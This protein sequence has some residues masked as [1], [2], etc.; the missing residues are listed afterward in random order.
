MPECCALHALLHAFRNCAAPPSHRWSALSTPLGTAVDVPLPG[1]GQGVA[2]RAWVSEASSSSK[3]LIV[4]LPS[5]GRPASD[6]NVLV[7][8]LSACGYRTAA[9]EYPGYS[10][11]YSIGAASAA[12]KYTLERLADELATVSRALRRQS[13]PVILLGWAFGNRPV[14]MCASRHPGLARGAV[15][16]S[17]GHEPTFTPDVKLA[18]MAVFQGIPVVGRPM[19]TAALRY[20][21]LYSPEDSPPAPVPS[22]LEQANELT[23]AIQ[24]LLG[25]AKWPSEPSQLEWVGGGGV[26]MLCVGGV[27][28]RIAPPLRSGHAL[29]ASLGADLVKVVDVA[30]AAHMVP[31]EKPNE[32]ATAI[33]SWLAEELAKPARYMPRLSKAS[34]AWSTLAAT[35]KLTGALKEMVEACEVRAAQAADEDEPED[36]MARPYQF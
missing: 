13:E 18:L 20:A 11:K 23:P 1:V 15:L 24:K 29:Q 10:P 36:D 35:V 32:V 8:S 5:R 28:D 4:C 3:A 34:H 25:D 16:L 21:C 22:E 17:A 30:G 27:D 12:G 6:F 26:P 7:A 9:V 19:Y 14:R 2:M 31:L 33:V